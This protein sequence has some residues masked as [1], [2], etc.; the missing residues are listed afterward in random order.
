MSKQSN[1]LESDYDGCCSECDG[2]YQEEPDY[3]SDY[4]DGYCCSGCEREKWEEERTYECFWCKDGEDTTA[5]CICNADRREEHDAALAA[6]RTQIEANPHGY[7]P[8]KEAMINAYAECNLL[9]GTN[10]GTAWHDA[11]ENYDV[12]HQYRDWCWYKG[13]KAC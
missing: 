9:Y 7:G 13:S 8:F 10:F 5:P 11:L 1:D 2:D 6:A 4:E 3:E 12:I